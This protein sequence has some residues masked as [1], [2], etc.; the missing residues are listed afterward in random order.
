MCVSAGQIALFW[1]YLPIVPE[2]PA[3]GLRATGLALLATGAFLGAV[4]PLL[5]PRAKVSRARLAPW[6]RVWLDFRDG[7][8][9]V[10]W[11]PVMERANALARDRGI[12]IRL[13]WHGFRSFPGDNS[14]SDA[15][16]AQEKIATLEMAKLETGLR[17]LLR[18]FVSNRW[19]D[20]RLAESEAPENLPNSALN[21]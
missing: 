6:N 3:D 13:D 16:A 10:W 9:L 18:R 1:N 21:A 2:L 19:I 4:H 11:H 20:R 17:N 5:S 12:P 8:G 15:S 14:A 7:F